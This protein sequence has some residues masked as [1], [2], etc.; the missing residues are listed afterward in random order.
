[1]LVVCRSTTP[2]S[3]MLD[4]RMIEKVKNRRILRKKVAVKLV[5]PLE[6]RANPKMSMGAHQR[7]VP[8]PSKRS[9][10]QPTKTVPKLPSLRVKAPKVGTHLLLMVPAR[11]NLLL[12]RGKKASEMTSRL[13][14]R[15]L[16]K[17]IRRVERSGKDWLKAE[18]LHLLAAFLQIL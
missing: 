5:L 4:L 17:K 7:L 15:K 10:K 8:S 16:Q 18:S 11:Q 2:P 12:E 14:L 13:R 9:P 1:M 3:L 6:H